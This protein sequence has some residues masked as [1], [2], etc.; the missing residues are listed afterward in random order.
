MCCLYMLLL[1][2]WD[3]RTVC[4]QLQWH[5]SSKTFLFFFISL[6]PLLFFSF[7]IFVLLLSLSFCS[8]IS[9]DAPTRW[10]WSLNIYH[11]TSQEKYILFPLFPCPQPPPQRAF[12]TL[13]CCIFCLSPPTLLSSSVWSPSFVLQ[14]PLCL[15]VSFQ[16]SILWSPQTL[17]LGVSPVILL[18]FPGCLSLLIHSLAASQ[19]LVCCLPRQPLL[20]WFSSFS[21]KNAV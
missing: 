17:D 12:C 10:R 14:P 16:T 1:C 15:L 5:S 7:V 3:E 6:V 9:T 4:F 20:I 18:L 11:F 21:F 2:I 13:F 8:L 19:I